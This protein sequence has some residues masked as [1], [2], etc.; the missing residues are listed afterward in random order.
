[1]LKTITIKGKSYPIAFGHSAFFDFGEETGQDIF[2]LFSIAEDDTRFKHNDFVKLTFYAFKHGALQSGKDFNLDIYEVMEILSSEL[3]ILER[4][5][6]LFSSSFATEEEK[7][8]PGQKV[9]TG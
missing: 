4:L 3:G 6:N 5:M 1:M 7:K 9:K 8:A 2:E